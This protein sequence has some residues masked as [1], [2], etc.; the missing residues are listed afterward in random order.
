[1]LFK[2]FPLLISQILSPWPSSI[3]QTSWKFHHC[4]Q[5]CI[6]TFFIRY[7]DFR[8]KNVRIMILLNVAIIWHI[9][10]RKCLFSAKFYHLELNCVINQQCCITFMLN[11]LRLD[12]TIG[13]CP[14]FL[15]EMSGILDTR[16]PPFCNSVDRVGKFVLIRLSWFN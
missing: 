3:S 12:A 13:K 4:T 14:N 7:P 11:M 15:P 16:I 10:L 2:N 9:K 6:K 8:L 5:S 1:M